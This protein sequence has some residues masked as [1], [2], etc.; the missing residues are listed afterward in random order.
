MV[1]VGIPREE[2]RHSQAV[3]DWL[4]KGRQE[5]LEEGRQEGEAALS[6]FPQ[7]NRRCGPLTGATT[8]RIKALPVDKLEALADALL[9]FQAPANLPAWLGTNA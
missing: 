3:K 4:A 1:I 5:G 6:P 7:L 2:I 8:A 9:G